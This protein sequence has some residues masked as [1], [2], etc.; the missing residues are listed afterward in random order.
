MKFFFSSKQC[1]IFKEKVNHKIFSFNAQFKS[2][3]FLCDVTL[4]N[5]PPAPSYIPMVLFNR[6]SVPELTGHPVQRPDSQEGS[7]FF[8][9]SPI[10]PMVLFNRGKFRLAKHSTLKT[11]SPCLRYK[12][13]RNRMSLSLGWVKITGAATV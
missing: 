5:V 11:P 2:R 4:R 10:A 1:L 3:I 9:L 13:I 6:G 12:S 8:C 7:S